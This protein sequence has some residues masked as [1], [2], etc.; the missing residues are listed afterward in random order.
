MAHAG[1]TIT[2]SLE[3]FGVDDYTR[4]STR[5]IARPPE[6]DERVLLELAA[7]R[8]VLVTESVNVDEQGVPIEFGIACFAADRVQLL[9]AG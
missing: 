6:Q 5:V 7:Q 4:R 2:G 1:G 8:P 9:F 3:R